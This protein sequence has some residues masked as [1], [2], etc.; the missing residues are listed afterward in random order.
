M[1]APV[2]TS[3]F[4]LSIQQQIK[5]YAQR[6]G[7]EVLQGY[8]KFFVSSFAVGTK[9]RRY[10]PL[11]WEQGDYQEILEVA[12]P[13]EDIAMND[14]DAAH[15]GFRQWKHLAPLLLKPLTVGPVAVTYHGKEIVI[16]AG[17]HAV[18]IH[19]GVEAMIFVVSLDQY[20]AMT[21]KSYPGRN[22]NKRK[23]ERIRS[24]VWPSTFIVPGSAAAVEPDKEHMINIFAAVVCQDR[25][26][27]ITDSTRLVQLHVM[28][29]PTMW[30]AHDLD[31]ESPHWCDLW[32]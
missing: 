16:A 11:T 10:T 22:P 32:K 31:V 12:Q 2:F 7:G 1:P 14:D 9:T 30:S 4:A 27:L 13:G 20:H 6:N 25:A 21:A 29:R 5:G 24:F 26:I 17:F 23:S 19:P 3:I 15:V 8:W 18:R 28:S